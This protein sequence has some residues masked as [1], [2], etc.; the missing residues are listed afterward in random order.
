MI[1]AAEEKARAG[2]EFS[3][4]ANSSMDCSAYEGAEEGPKLWGMLACEYI[5]RQ[6]RP[7]E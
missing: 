7:C 4:R 6:H 5:A 3:M 1:S 2:D